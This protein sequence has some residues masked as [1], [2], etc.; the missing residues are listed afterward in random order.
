MT[1][2]ALGVS[3]VIFLAVAYFVIRI[4]LHR[5]LKNNS[6]LDEVYRNARISGHLNILLTRLFRL[7]VEE[8]MELSETRARADEMIAECKNSIEEEGCSESQMEQLQPFFDRLKTR[9]YTDKRGE[10]T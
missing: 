9:I 4:Y 1:D 5:S 3:L 8:N 7:V 10:Q 2:W 6:I